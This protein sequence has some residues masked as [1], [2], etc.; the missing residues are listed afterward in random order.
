VEGN[1]RENAGEFVAESSELGSSL[2]LFVL[3]EV[4]VGRVGRSIGEI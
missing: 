2:F 1:L 3:L 4:V